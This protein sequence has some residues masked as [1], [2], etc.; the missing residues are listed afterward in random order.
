MPVK[1]VE[2]NKYATVRVILGRRIKSTRKARKATQLEVARAIGLSGGGVLSQFENGKK[3]PGL[4]TL[5]KIADALLCDVS[6]LLP[7]ISEF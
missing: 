5:Y 4:E 2:K 3:G 7:S 1:K 6:D